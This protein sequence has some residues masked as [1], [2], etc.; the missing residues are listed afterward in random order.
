[1]SVSELGTTGIPLDPPVVTKNFAPGLGEQTIN[2]WPLG[3]PENIQ[4]KYDELVALSGTGSNIETLNAKFNQ[5]RASLVASYTRT[6]TEWT[7]DIV[8]IEELYA[9][10]V[11]KDVCNSDYFSVTSNGSKGL[12]LTDDQV[13][14]VR[15]CSD[16]GFSEADITNYVNN[17]PAPRKVPGVVWAS[18]SIGMKEYRYHLLHGAESFYETGFVLRKSKYGVRTSPVAQAFDNI[19]RVV[20]APTLSS[21]M[22][23]LLASLP[24]GEW[25]YRPPQAEHLGRGR[26]RI[27]EEW[28]WAVKWSVVYGGTWNLA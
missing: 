18:W 3:T 8:I 4:A 16:M 7:D 11:I 14:F 17:P 22:D 9:V 28:N 26:W 19:N 23:Y 12:P 2:E 6:S 20:T 21:Q 1:M 13:A 5:G 25:L 27:T 15:Y 24:T 10:D